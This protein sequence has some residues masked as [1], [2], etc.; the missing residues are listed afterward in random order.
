MFIYPP[1]SQLPI[2]WGSLRNAVKEDFVPI[3][4]SV[5]AKRQEL[6]RAALPKDAAMLQ[7]SIFQQFWRRGRRDGEISGRWR[8]GEMAMVCLEVHSWLVVWNINF[9]F[10]YIGKAQA[11]RGTRSSVTAHW[12]SR[13]AV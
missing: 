1:S 3:F 13:L 2:P 9:I 5:E 6:A 10:P 8:D 12:G 7:R 4:A 11:M